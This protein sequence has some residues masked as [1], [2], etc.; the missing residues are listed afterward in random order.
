[1]ENENSYYKWYLLSLVILT[2]M[3]VVAIPAMAMSVLAEEISQDLH[4]DLVQVGIVWGIGALPGIL[5]GLLGGAI[6]D[7]I[8]PKRILIVGCLL[9]GLVGAAR[10]LAV[11]FPSMVVVVIVGGALAPVIVMNG[12]KTCG[13]WFPARQLGLANGLISMGMALGF[14]L[15]AILSATVLSPLLGGWRNVLILYGLAGAALALPWFFTRTLQLSQQTAQP[16][17]SIRQ[18]VAHV[19]RL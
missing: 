6:G 10:G 14:L 4:L 7:K 8:G 1:M 2:N 16:Q 13:L 5:T 17:I 15:G 11:D 18:T 12:M 19:A 9:A 3:L